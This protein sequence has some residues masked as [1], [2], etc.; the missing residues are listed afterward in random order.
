MHNSATFEEYSRTC[1]TYVCH[2]LVIV[3]SLRDDLGEL[4]RQSKFLFEKAS[5]DLSNI[6]FGICVDDLRSPR[7]HLG[8]FSNLCENSGSPMM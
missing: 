2:C 1:L 5:D 4:R 3:G 8:P 7:N 6:F